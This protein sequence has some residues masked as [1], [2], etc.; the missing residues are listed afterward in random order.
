MYIHTGTVFPRNL[1]IP[2]IITALK[3]SLHFQ[4][5]KKTAVELPLHQLGTRAVK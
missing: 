2:R 1:I 4:A 3:M 5:N